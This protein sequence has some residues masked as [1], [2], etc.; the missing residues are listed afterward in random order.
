MAERDTLKASKDIVGMPVYS[1]QEGQNLGQVKSLVIDTEKKCLLALVVE[2]KR[3]TKEERLL[4]FAAIKSL[5]DDVITVE[6]GQALE[7]RGVDPATMR[8]LRRPVQ[9]VGARC[10]TAG[11]KTMGKVEEYFVDITDGRIAQLEIS[12]GGLIKGKVLV[13]GE[14]IIALAPHTVMLSDE[15]AELCRPAPAG[16]NL[17]ASMEVA[18][19]K[20]TSF[21]SGSLVKIKGGA[22]E[23]AE[24]PPE[25]DQVEENIGVEVP[26]TVEVLL[27]EEAEEVGTPVNAPPPGLAPVLPAE[28]EEEEEPSISGS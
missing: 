19:D 1:I 28:D 8:A 2:K 20:A 17:L 26:L 9:P 12:E 27:P 5:G 24:A 4:P 22:K 21:I 23:E 3:L 25:E 16:N 15:A 18:K 10:F 14:H 6:R 11:G 13:D 7:R